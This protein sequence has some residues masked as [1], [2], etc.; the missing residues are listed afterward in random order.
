MEPKDKQLPEPNG[1]GK[2][3]YLRPGWPESKRFTLDEDDKARLGTGRGTDSRGRVYE[4]HYKP[5]PHHTSID[6]EKDCPECVELHSGELSGYRSRHP[7][8]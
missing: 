7:L 2:D 6:Y 3:T 5:T 4:W 8:A 1:P